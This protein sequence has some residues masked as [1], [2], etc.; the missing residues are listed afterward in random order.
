M[1]GEAS[2]RSGELGEELAKEFL[3]LIGWGNSLSAITIPCALPEKHHTKSHGDDQLFIYNSPFTQDETVVVHVSV[4]HKSGGYGKGAQG[5]R[6]ELKS[7]LTELNTIVACAQLSPEVARII[8]SSPCNPR[9]IHRGLL[10]WVHSDKDTLER[11]IRQD[12][13]S[14]QLSQEYTTPVFLVDSGRASFIYCAISHYQNQH[15]GDY[16]FYYPRLGTSIFADPVRAGKTLPLELIASDVIPIKG[17]QN[18][19]PLLYLYVREKFSLSALT[20]ACALSRDFGD[21]WVQ[22]IHIGFEDYNES[23]HGQLR[24]EALLA[25][26]GSDTQI[27]VFSYKDSVLSLLEGKS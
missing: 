18:E 13:G 20:K 8:K 26:V 24:D 11:D 2:K 3:R 23:I 15:L 21:A 16:H 27:S 14:I 19:K 22:D 12:I 25:F 6:T 9:K 4:K 1:S 17:M 5:L 10:I 7:H